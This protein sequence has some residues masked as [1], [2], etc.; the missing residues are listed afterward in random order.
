MLYKKSS[1]NIKV[2]LLSIKHFGGIMICDIDII[3]HLITKYAWLL[4]CLQQNGITD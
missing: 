4:K 1:I 3:I 2:D